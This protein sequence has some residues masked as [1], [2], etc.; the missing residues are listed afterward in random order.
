VL[1]DGRV[2]QLGSHETLIADVDGLYW[3]F[4]EQQRLREDLERYMQLDQEL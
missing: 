4:Y 1:V 3:R 2:A